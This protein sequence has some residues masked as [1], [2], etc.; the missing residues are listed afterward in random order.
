MNE[1]DEVLKGY[2]EKSFMVYKELKRMDPKI[3]GNLN[4]RNYP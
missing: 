4:V 3:L 2:M 1:F